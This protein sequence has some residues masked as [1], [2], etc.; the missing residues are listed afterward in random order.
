V[1][2]MLIQNTNP[3]AVAPH[4][5]KVR[6]GFSRDDLFVCV[7]EQ[8]MTDTARYADI[9][10]PA[11]MFMEHDDI[12]TAGGHPHLEFAPKVID[13][14]GG[15]HSNHEVIAA[16][17]RR[18]TPSIPPSQCRPERSLIG[19]CANRAT[20]I[21]QRSRESVGST[22]NRLSKRRTSSTALAFPTGSF[23][24]RRIG[25]MRL[26]PTTDCAAPGARCR[27]CLTISQPM[28]RPTKNALLSSRRHP[29][30]TS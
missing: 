21:S 22:C 24:S 30:E 10:L 9:V 12:Y 13:P 28:K 4:Q 18:I 26:S 17:A 7:H 5:E 20:A 29:P 16:L 3:L 2:A 25:Q 27:A 19:R 15:C 23:G 11:T 8:F 14:P 6:R 1:R